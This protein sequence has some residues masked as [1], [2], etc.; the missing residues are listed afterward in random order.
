MEN[1]NQSTVGCS[2][3]ILFLVMIVGVLLMFTKTADL[4]AKHSPATI[5]GYNYPELYGVVVACIVDGVV[6]AMKMKILFSGRAKNQIEWVFDILLTLFPFGV[7]ALAQVFDDFETN[8][9]LA[10]QP[11]L[12]QALNTW[13][14]PS[15]PTV[16]VLGILL[17][18]F[19]QSAPDGMFSVGKAGG[20]GFHL[21]S[22]HLPNFG[23]SFGSKPK[24]QGSSAKQNPPNPPLGD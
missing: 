23:K 8:G 2:D 17:Y 15:I 6:I 10:N 3:L 22:F 7:S 11:Q 18:G 12:V 5:F 1:K 14:V 19:I 4:M 13:G 9:T 20:A 21:P 16:I 24:Q